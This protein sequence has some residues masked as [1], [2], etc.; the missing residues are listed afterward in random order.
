MF[1]PKRHDAPTTCYHI[2]IA[3]LMQGRRQ[4]SVQK[5]QECELVPHTVR[6]LASRIV[7]HYSRL[8]HMPLHINLM[9]R[10]KQRWSPPTTLCSIAKSTFIGPDAHCSRWHKIQ[11]RITS[12]QILKHGLHARTAALSRRRAMANSHIW[13]GLDIGQAGSRIRNISIID[14]GRYQLLCRKREG[15]AH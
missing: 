10:P 5:R 13:R 1:A 3:A 4:T 15:L 8:T 11:H 6:G 7:R 14:E 2:S 12:T 9:P